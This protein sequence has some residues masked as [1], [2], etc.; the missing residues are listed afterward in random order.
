[1][2][3]LIY[4]AECRD[5]NNSPLRINIYR[6]TQ[7]EVTAKELVLASEPIV[8]DY[9]SDD[10]FQ[11][12]KQSA[13]T[14]NV[15]T[16]EVLLDLYTGSTNEVTVQVYKNGR[17][18]WFGFLTPN[19][20][21]SEYNS[22][23]DLL[24]LEFIDSIAQLENIKY[25]S[26][27][28]DFITFLEVIHKAF[29]QIDIDPIIKYIVYPDT[30][31]IYSDTNLLKGLYVQT[32]NFIDEG[33]EPETYKWILSELMCYLGFSMMQYGNSIYI[34]DYEGIRNEDSTP[35]VLY[36]RITGSTLQTPPPSEGAFDVYNLGIAETNGSISLGNVYNQVNL[37]ANTNP[38]GDLIP[39]LFDDLTNQNADPNKYY[40]KELNDT[41][42]L[43]AY[44]NSS[45]WVTSGAFLGLAEPVEEVTLDLMYKGKNGAVVNGGIMA[46]TVFQKADSY[47]N[48]DG[49]PS[50]LDWNDYLTMILT[51]QF[52]VI[53]Y[54]KPNLQIEKKNQIFKGGNIIIDINYMLSQTPIVTDKEGSSDAVFYD[55]QYSAGI[56]DTKFKSKL[57]IGDYYYNGNE[58]TTTESYFYLARKNKVGEPIFNNFYNLT[59]QVSY[60]DNLVDTGDGVLIRLP[61]SVLY[62]TFLF[63]LYIPDGMATKFNPRT[64]KVDS[65]TIPYY[66]HIK[67]LKVVYTN[68]KHYVDIFNEEKNDEDILYSSVIDE[69]YIT[70]MDDLDFK[71]NTYSPNIGSYSYV[72]HK[73][74]NTYDFV[75]TFQYAGQ[76]KKMEEFILEK[77]VD[78]YSKPKMIYTNT[79]NNKGYVM[80]F[81]ML[82]ESLLKRK[83]IP[84]SISY[85]LLDDTVTVNAKEV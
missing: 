31:K 12:L 48:E 46:G 9:H 39:D 34:L 3:Q 23:L 68:Q 7:E 27:D 61:D 74:G 11:P 38:I 52:Q 25:K 18:F 78:Y 53:P 44:F 55:G 70:E 40:Q 83:F 37:V 19:V 28:D 47:K 58:W 67:D 82:Y 30:L 42:H 84:D 14:I 32:R 71:I 17:L 36:N 4:Y 21:S 51:N 50:T 1:M 81:T 35:Y 64:D 49:K 41:T 66:C 73:V 79:L 75:D 56:K 69:K 65:Y 72:L 85:N 16:D 62:G 6:D 10:L 43:T 20:Y 77:Y 76:E 57:Q 29:N 33:E 15:L 24:S 5:I 45:K 2:A 60:E 8:I 80:P 54:L 63:E 59:N 13:C 26:T 22:N